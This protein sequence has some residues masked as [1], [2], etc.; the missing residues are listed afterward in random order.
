MRHR[1]GLEVYTYLRLGSVGKVSDRERRGDFQSVVGRPDHY[2]FGV[3]YLIGE[4]KISEI[5]KKS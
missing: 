5:G 3:G 4:V 2:Q 1:R